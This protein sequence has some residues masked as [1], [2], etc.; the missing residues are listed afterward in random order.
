MRVSL[1]KK[2]PYTHDHREFIFH[3]ASKCTAPNPANATFRVRRSLTQ[4]PQRAPREQEIWASVVT[5]QKV[6]KTRLS[7]LSSRFPL[8]PLRPLREVPVC[9]G[10]ASGGSRQDPNVGIYTFHPP[11]NVALPR[12]KQKGS[13]KA[14]LALQKLAITITN[15]L[16]PGW[17]FSNNYENFGT[18]V[19]M[20]HS[21][22]SEE[23]KAVF[24]PRRTISSVRTL[25]AICLVTSATI[26]PPAQ[27]AEPSA[28][29]C[30]LV[31]KEGKVE[32]ARK[33]S[34]TWSLAQP[35]EKLQTGDRLRTGLR[36]RATLR[37]SELSV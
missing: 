22:C 34:T 33:G 35:D 23:D 15:T 29:P 17:C 13:K 11:K 32:I 12:N 4:S 36:S 1:K 18:I 3:K 30:I 24:F 28:Q 9:I 8:R 27:A 37:W 26:L 10:T 25:L 6:N 31:E 7:H 16:D 14:S 5:H 19:F 2:G 21:V 20:M